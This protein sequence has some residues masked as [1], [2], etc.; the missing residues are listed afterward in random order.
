VTDWKLKRTAQCRK[1]PWRVGVDPHDIPSGYCVDK[2]VALA[3]T[4]AELGALPEPDAPLRVMT[5][6]D[7]LC[8][9]VPARMPAS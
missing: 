4:I 9:S 2:H 7:M 6:H 8:A 3:S 1:C 5:C